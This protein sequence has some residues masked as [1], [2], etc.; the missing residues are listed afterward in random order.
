MPILIRVV[1]N[2]ERTSNGSSLI[3]GAIFLIEMTKVLIA[4]ERLMV[5]FYF[6]ITMIAHDIG[7]Y[8]FSHVSGYS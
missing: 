6:E 1:E 4:L 2:R 7:H 3:P 8:P 5:D